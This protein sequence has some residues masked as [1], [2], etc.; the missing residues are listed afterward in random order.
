M[1]TLS[2]NVDHVATVREARKIS[3]PDPVHAALIAELAGAHGITIHLR[4]DRR[5][6]QERDLKLCRQLI[7]TKL[8]LEMALNQEII[9]IALEQVPDIVTLVP[10]KPD[11]ITTEGGLNV[12]QHKSAIANNISM[13]EEREI[14]VSLFVDPD[15]D[16]IKAAHEVGAKVIEINTGRYADAPRKKDREQQY[17]IILDAVKMATKLR[18]QIAA[19]HGLDYQNVGAIAAIPGVRELNIGHAVISRSI[20]VGI[21]Q[22]VRE[23][24]DAMAE[25]V[26]MEV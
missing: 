17:R 22:A 26:M 6:I 23:L 16:Q 11:E 3:Q 9:R 15:L 25:G 1:V 4:A 5:H 2:V 7:K 19:G 20:F 21:D 18:L 10:E 14:E 24:L 12:L 13:F 8:N